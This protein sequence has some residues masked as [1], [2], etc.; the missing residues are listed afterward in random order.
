MLE[1]GS[2][3]NKQGE[4][5]TLL[6]YQAHWMEN[7][8]MILRLDSDIYILSFL[9][10]IFGVSVADNKEGREI[11]QLTKAVSSPDESC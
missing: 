1:Q 8:W 10:V 4:M 5:V 7:C 3:P 6:L 11:P 2:T 9:K